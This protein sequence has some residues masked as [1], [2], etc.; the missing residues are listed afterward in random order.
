MPRIVSERVFCRGAGPQWPECPASVGRWFVVPLASVP[1]DILFPH[2]P[3][4]PEMPQ[5]LHVEKVRDIVHDTIM[6]ADKIA[7]SL[8]NVLKINFLGSRKGDVTGSNL[9]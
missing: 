1:P 8:T 2:P 3:L 4:L 5:S 7:V 6:K 9:G